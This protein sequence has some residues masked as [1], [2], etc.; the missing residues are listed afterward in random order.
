MSLRNCVFV[1]VHHSHH[2]AN[3]DNFIQISC[4]WFRPFQLFI[5]LALSQLC[6]N[7]HLLLYNFPV[8]HQADH[9]HWLWSSPAFQP[10]CPTFSPVH[11]NS[12]TFSR[13]L[14]LWK[15]TDISLFTL[16][17]AV[18]PLRFF[19][20]CRRLSFQSK[21]L[22]S[23]AIRR[24]HT[25]L[26][27]P[28]WFPFEN[29]CVPPNTSIPDVSPHPGH[30]PPALNDSTSEVQRLVQHGNWLRYAQFYSTT[31]SH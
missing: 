4:C 6:T 27:P 17:H 26:S 8:R 30:F 1:V 20:S 11:H 7:N 9:S 15:F 13:L 24:F 21:S 19:H 14:K 2:P 16:W 22:W 28:R 10:P 25:A 5:L 12:P 18:P 29:I 23:L 3:D 31:A